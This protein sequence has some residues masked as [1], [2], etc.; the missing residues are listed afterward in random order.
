MADAGHRDHLTDGAR[1]VRHRA[2]EICVHHLERSKRPLGPFVLLALL[3]LGLFTLLSRSRPHPQTAATPI[4]RRFS[5]AIPATPAPPKL[6][7][8]PLAGPPAATETARPEVTEPKAA[9]PGTTAAA[10]AETCDQTV[11]FSTNET[12][13]ADGGAPQLRRLVECLKADPSSSVS[14]EGRV[15]PRGNAAYNVS[16]AERRAESVAE[17]LNALG[18]PASRVTT[19]I[20]EELCSKA[21][22]E[23]W[24]KNRSVTATVRR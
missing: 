15:D 18:V 14:L 2:D 11:E 5:R 20:G 13:L 4:E 6:S 19:S 9:E 21:T 16:L 23:C 7:E 10:G 8:A 22:E 3:A 17:A 12:A 1:E 24:Q